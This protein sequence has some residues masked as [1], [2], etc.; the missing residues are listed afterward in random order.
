METYM[1]N[2]VST[3]FVMFCEREDSVKVYS[4]IY[5][6]RPVVGNGESLIKFDN[7]FE[8]KKYIEANTPGI[9]RIQ[10]AS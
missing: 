4:T 9:R 2:V 10:F 5:L 6:Y 1:E 8:A 3:C 7:I